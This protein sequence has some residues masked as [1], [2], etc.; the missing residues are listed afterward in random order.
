MSILFDKTFEHLIM[1]E[2]GYVNDPKDSGGATRYGITENTARSHGYTG[3]MSELP[4][5]E[6]QRIYKAAYWDAVYGD[7]IGAFSP[8]IAAELFDTAVNMGI[9]F[10]GTCLQRVL[11]AMNRNGT[12]YPDVTIDGAVGP[13][14]VAALRAYLLK[15]KLDGEVVLLRA[16]NA[17]QGARYIELAETRQ[18]DEA[19]VFGWLLRRV[20]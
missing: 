17:L 7:E 6:A 11:S 4:L 20:K 8:E 13:A 19:F 3:Q 12:D 15:R 9:K 1:I 18:K 16:L 2:G 5:R 10:A 14:T